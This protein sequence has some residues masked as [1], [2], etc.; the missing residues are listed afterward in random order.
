[1]E[2]FGEGHVRAA[3]YDEERMRIES[4]AAEIEAQQR[5]Q[6]R[7]EHALSKLEDERIAAEHDKTERILGI[8]LARIAEQERT[9]ALLANRPQSM[10]ASHDGVSD[11]ARSGNRV[12]AVRLSGEKNMSFY[13]STTYHRELV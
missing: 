4:K 11:R 2:H 9:K 8:Q 13:A 6:E 3:Q 1:M 7:Y 5:A 10:H 12:V